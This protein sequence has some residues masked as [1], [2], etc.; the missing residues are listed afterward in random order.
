MRKF[1]FS[2]LLIFSAFLNTAAAQSTCVP[3]KIANQ[4]SIVACGPG[5]SGSKFTSTEKICPSGAVIVSALD[6]SGCRPAPGKKNEVNS[7]NKCLVTPDACAGLPTPAGCPAGMHWTL[8]GSKIAHCVKDDFACP[9]GSSLAYDALG[10]PSCATN[11]CPS[12]QVLQGN[13]SSCACPPGQPLWNGSTCYAPVVTCTPNSWTNGAVACGA[14]FSG[15]MYT[16]SSTSCPSGQYGAPSTSTS[17]YNTSGCSCANGGTNYPT[18]TIVQ[19]EPS[20]C[21]ALPGFNRSSVTDG[22][23]ANDNGTNYEDMSAGALGI[24]SR[25]QTGSRW[26]NVWDI[27]SG[28]GGSY[29]VKLLSSR[30]LTYVC[31]GGRWTR[32]NFPG[33]LTDL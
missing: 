18:C 8:A 15:S 27:V 33:Y 26:T 20:S 1:I 30:T 11:T 9:W 3:F 17:G 14:G 7:T 28:R 25:G 10:H 32:T 2:A 12:N 22:W 19:P 6:T 16:T 5:Q 31:S 4:N 21:P 13:G 23:W 24:G 29:S